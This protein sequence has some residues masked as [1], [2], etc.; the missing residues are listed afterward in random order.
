MGLEAGRARPALGGRRQDRRHERQ[1][2]RARCDRG[3]R[4]DNREARLVELAEVG[5]PVADGGHGRAA[6]VEHEADTRGA[7]VVQGDDY[8]LTGIDAAFRAS[9]VDA[10]PACRASRSV[11]LPET[12][13]EK[14]SATSL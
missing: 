5:A 7:E 10:W 12:A 8:S 14:P 9:M 2:G 1:I 4:G 3:R 6:G 11:P 13:P